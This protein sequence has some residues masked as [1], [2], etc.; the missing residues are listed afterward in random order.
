MVEIVYSSPVK[1]QTL[2]THPRGSGLE[3]PHS[4]PGPWGGGGWEGAGRGIPAAAF[5]SAR[6][7]GWLVTTRALSVSELLRAKGVRAKNKKANV[8]VICS[9]RD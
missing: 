4:P 3:R 2:K 1:V 9:R 8:V 5:P 7:G 6:A